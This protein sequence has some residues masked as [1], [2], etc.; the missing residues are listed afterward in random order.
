M[1]LKR[2]ASTKSVRTT[3][4]LFGI[5]VVVVFTCILA[6]PLP[7]HADDDIARTLAAELLIAQGDLA[8]LNEQEQ[9]TAHKTGLRARVRG[10]LG[11][12]PWMLRRQNDTA[13]ADA[14]RPWQNRTLE[15]QGNRARLLDLLEELSARHPLDQSYF[16]LHPSRPSIRREAASIHRSYCAGC[17]DDAGQGDPDIELPARNLFSMALRETP[18]V[19]LA[20]LINGVKGD[21]TLGFVN[22]LNDTQIAALW[23]FY[24]SPQRDT[25]R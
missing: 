4:M 25:N 23:R 11:V 13:G 9:P 6:A 1:A 7:G 8:R 19:F 10:A 24:L 20:R 18:E 12:L 2:H 5:A 3:A 15:T 17:H 22:P 21:E 16:N 14:L